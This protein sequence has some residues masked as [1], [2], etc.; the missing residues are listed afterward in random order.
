MGMPNI[1]VNDK[2]SATALTAYRE[3][4]RHLAYAVVNSAAMQ[5]IS[6][7]ATVHYEI[8]PWRIWL[9][10]A[11]GIVLLFILATAAILWKE[12]RK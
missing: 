1:S 2:A 4:I 5:G 11:D 8:S 9:Y 3:N 6:A 10:A 12:K 7:G